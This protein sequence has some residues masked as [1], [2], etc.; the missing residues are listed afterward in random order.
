MSC[1]EWISYYSRATECSRP[2][3]EAMA[4]K[5]QT[6]A[7]ASPGASFALRTA[8]ILRSFTFNEVLETR[9]DFQVRIIPKTSE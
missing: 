6:L 8:L 2:W 1:V 5:A 9:A 4:S 3:K 7:A